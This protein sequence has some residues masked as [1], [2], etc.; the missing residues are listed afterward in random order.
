MNSKKNRVLGRILAIEEITTI[1]GAK[2][3]APCYDYGTDTNSTYDCLTGITTDTGTVSD[4]IES[5]SVLKK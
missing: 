4:Q 1:S 5:L 3:T 2:N